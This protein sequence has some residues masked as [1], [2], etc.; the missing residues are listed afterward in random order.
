MS[1][2]N[3]NQGDSHEHLPLTV[4]IEGREFE[5][6]HQYIT[7]K[8]LRELGK[9][10]AD[11]DLC[12]AIADPW[13]DEPVGPGSRIDLAREG[14]E[15]FYVR[16]PLLLTVDSSQYQWQKQYITTKEL[17]KLAGISPQHEIYLLL[18]KPYEDE[19]LDENTVINLARPGIEHFKVKKKDEDLK[20]SI[21]IND[22][23]YQ[24]KRGVYTVVEIKKLGNVPLGDELSEL[25]KGKL[26]PLPDKGSVNI[27]GGEEFF[28]CK[29]E[30]AS[31]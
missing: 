3:T 11:A 16:N 21:K 8:E 1:K 19:L 22:N 9:L 18:E 20:V 17:R 31:S 12:L 7:G 24:V 2:Q 23:P 13:D 4:I 26:E 25:V 10:P 6:P 5:W 29:R 15:G 27:K 30:G 14:V 28:S